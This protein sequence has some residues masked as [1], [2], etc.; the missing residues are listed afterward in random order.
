[1]ADGDSIAQV[2]VV[3]LLLSLS[4]PTLATA[5]DYAGTPFEYEETTTINFTSN[6]SVE[7]NATLEDY[8]ESPTI[9]SNGSELVQGT[10]YEWN[11]TSGVVN[12][13]D[14]QN[15]TDGDGATI[16]YVAYQRT[17]ETVVARNLIFPFM[18]L[19]GLFAFVT[20]VRALWQFAAEV[21]DIS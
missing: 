12:W 6:Y 3:I 14:T 7:Q 21:W 16:Q 19:F 9:T 13:I 5:Y 15:T 10:D 17:R 20:S 2:A 4:I 18:G 1:M 11:A 8:G